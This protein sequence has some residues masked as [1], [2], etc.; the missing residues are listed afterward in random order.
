MN[1]KQKLFWLIVATFFWASCSE[2]ETVTP[3]G[4]GGSR[5]TVLTLKRAG[6]DSLKVN[7]LAHQLVG[8]Y[9]THVP[10]DAWGF[11][12]R[13]IS[14]YSSDTSLVLQNIQVEFIGDTI[15]Y[16]EVFQ[17]SQVANFN[18]QLP[19]ADYQT[20]VYA[21]VVRG[22]SGAF[23]SLQE[24]YSFASVGGLS[25]GYVDGQPL[26]FVTTTPTSS[27]TA[28][29]GAIIPTNNKILYTSSVDVLSVKLSA[30]GTTTL[31]K[32]FF[33]N[34]SIGSV[35]IKVFNGST[36]IGSKSI[37]DTGSVLLS[38][39]VAGGS[40]VSLTVQATFSLEQ[41]V[42]VGQRV[43]IENLEY[44]DD[45]KDVH[46]ISEEVYSSSIYVYKVLPM[47][48]FT[49]LSPTLHEGTFEPLYTFS[50]QG[51]VIKQWSYKTTISDL[52]EQND[53]FV[54]SLALF[55]NGVDV[56]SDYY[57]SDQN[58]TLITAITKGVMQVFLS[59][60]GGY[61]LNALSKQT[62]VLKGVSRNGG[63]D[64]EDA[65]QLQ[66]LLDDAESGEH[67][68]ANGFG[69]ANTLAVGQL[70][71]GTPYHFI[72]SDGRSYTHNAITNLSSSDWMNSSSFL[73]SAAVQTFS[74]Q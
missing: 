65:L 51:G 15:F 2:K 18:K 9:T 58:G 62:I 24:A 31:K 73:V 13:Q 20:L 47:F 70:M 40:T 54:D 38:V 25:T 44:V 69:Y 3:G 14:A 17:T 23:V 60:K 27:L 22:K 53:I 46:T 64:G 21:D 5:D 56:T 19:P 45:H 10:E 30:E 55:I 29:I 57:I 72:W 63:L 50:V 67:Y 26:S 42:E 36:V 28:D 43:V 52:H 49:A 39:G 11:V 66:L 12:M 6:T 74:L 34:P 35:D 37:S 7:V 61:E 8:K 1:K 41:L 32:I 4:T 48:T 16:S 33:R 68:L 71:G 59:R